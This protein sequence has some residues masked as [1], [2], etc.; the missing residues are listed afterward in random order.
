MKR[1]RESKR[2]I[3][4]YISV[5]TPFSEERKEMIPISSV[6]PI[7]EVI[8]EGRNYADTREQKVV[9]NYVLISGINDSEQHLLGLSQLLDPNHFD[10]TLNLLNP[11][12]GRKLNPSSFERLD[13][14]N[15]V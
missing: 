2:G 3:K 6:Y 11:T 7:R 13:R 12:P 1:L 8:A 14:L 15:K 5:H 10:V 9:A 4:L